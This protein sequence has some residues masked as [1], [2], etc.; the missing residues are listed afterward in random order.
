M[1]NTKIADRLTLPLA[2]EEVWIKGGMS[3]DDPIVTLP[4]GDIPAGVN[5]PI[6]FLQCTTTME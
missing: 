1:I 2:R 5:D 3:S 6:E 4:V